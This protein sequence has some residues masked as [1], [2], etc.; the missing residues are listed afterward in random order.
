MR[1]IVMRTRVGVERRTN[2]RENEEER[3]VEVNVRLEEKW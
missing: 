2:K 3:L 1:E